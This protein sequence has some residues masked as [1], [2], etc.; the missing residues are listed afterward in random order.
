MGAAFVVVPFLLRAV[1]LVVVYKLES[2]RKF[3]RFIKWRKLM[4]VWTGSV[5]GILAGAVFTYVAMPERYS[6]YR[7]A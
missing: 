7:L 5:I 3:F 1:R 6:M 2:R 4:I